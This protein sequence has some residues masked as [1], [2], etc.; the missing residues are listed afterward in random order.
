MGCVQEVGSGQSI[1]GGR[2]KKR[3][4]QTNK[5]EKRRENRRK[6]RRDVALNKSNSERNVI[7]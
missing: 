4:I 5:E 2:R 1:T 7:C 6:E 3:E